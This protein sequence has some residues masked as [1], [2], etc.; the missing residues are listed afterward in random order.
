M[1][2]LIPNEPWKIIRVPNDPCFSIHP[3][4]MPVWRIV[5]LRLPGM[6]KSVSGFVDLVNPAAFP[7]LI[8]RR[9][10]QA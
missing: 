5:R 6:I 3:P 9:K 7:V 4:S 2:W 8:P 1:K 10:D